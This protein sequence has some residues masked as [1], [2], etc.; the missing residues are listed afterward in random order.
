MGFRGEL[1]QELQLNISATGLHPNEEMQGYFV[2]FVK[3]YFTEIVTECSKKAKEHHLML[4][5]MVKF[6]YK[7]AK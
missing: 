5:I 6:V 4:T 2:S 7:I 3:Y 1:S